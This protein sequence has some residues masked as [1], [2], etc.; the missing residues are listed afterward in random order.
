MNN[1]LP[2]K[3][4][5]HQVR[6]AQNPQQMLQSIIAKNPQLQSFMNLAHNNGVSL[7]QVARMLAQQKGVDINTVINE[8]NTQ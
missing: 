1:L 2:I 4:L 7:E 3:N 8:L 5:M 6:A